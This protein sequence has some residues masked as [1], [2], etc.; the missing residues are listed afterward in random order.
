MIRALATL[1]SLRPALTGFVAKLSANVAGNL[2]GV[3]WLALSFA[4]GHCTDVHRITFVLPYSVLAPLR[5]R[6][7]VV[8]SAIWRLLLRS[9]S[10][11]CD[12]ARAVE[13]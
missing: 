6:G 5:C 3:A 12:H 10:A 4:F 2:V 13:I 7:P 8:P 9:G 11:H 1:L